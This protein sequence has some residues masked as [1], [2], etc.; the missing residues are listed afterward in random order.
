MQMLPAGVAGSSAGVKESSVADSTATA[1]AEDSLTLTG[2][3]RTLSAL[4][5]LS[6]PVFPP[7]QSNKTSV[8]RLQ[9]NSLNWQSP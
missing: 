3:R 9:D 7:A 6:L 2:S 1:A 8:P 5:L 4:F